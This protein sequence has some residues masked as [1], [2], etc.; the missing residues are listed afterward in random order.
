MIDPETP[1]TSTTHPPAGA[2]AH[3][4][5]ISSSSSSTDRP[6]SLDQLLRVGTKRS[7]SPPPQTVISSL[8]KQ[9]LAS[10]QQPTSSSQRRVIM[11][12][13]SE[14]KTL[15]LSL[16]KKIESQ[17]RIIQ[18]LTNELK[19]ARAERETFRT[20]YEG[21]K[22]ENRLLKGSSVGFTALRPPSSASEELDV[23]PTIIHK[24]L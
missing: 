7:A 22:T 3:F 18:E 5:I 20:L 10:A 6:F 8:Q 14:D 21:A 1:S 12:P 24:P 13:T 11:K 16:F 19:S 23:K 2:T 15:I 17:E 9:L 4:S